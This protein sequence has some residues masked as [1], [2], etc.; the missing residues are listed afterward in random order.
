[1]KISTSQQFDYLQGH[2]L[3]V[4]FEETRPIDSC[5]SA[6]HSQKCK[7]TKQLDFTDKR[8]TLQKLE[9]M[10]VV[11]SL[12]WQ[13]VIIFSMTVVKN[14]PSK[15]DPY[16]FADSDQF[17][18]LKIGQWRWICLQFGAWFWWTRSKANPG[19]LHRPRPHCKFWFFSSINNLLSRQSLE[20][21]IC[22]VEEH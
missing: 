2:F 5:F 17:S 13:Q 11:G 1:M 18:K 20:R 8:S 15:V 3:L 6:T 12:R 22:I 21:G 7:K 14:N 9:G 4:I 10:G 16:F 19:I